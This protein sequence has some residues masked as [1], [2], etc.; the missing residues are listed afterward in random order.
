MTPTPCRS[1]NG[2]HPSVVNLSLGGTTHLDALDA[3]VKALVD[4]GVVMV[5]A[6]ANSG[7]DVGDAS[8]ADV[9][10][11]ITVGAMEVHD[12]VPSFSNFG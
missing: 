6:A 2:A 4:Q 7:V 5:I 3:A 8:P 9:A 12:A 1:T 11:A 10:E